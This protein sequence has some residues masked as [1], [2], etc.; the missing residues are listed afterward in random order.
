MRTGTIWVDVGARDISGLASVLE[1][2]TR[3]P[4]ES[5]RSGDNIRGFTSIGVN[6]LA[7]HS[8]FDTDITVELYGKQLPYN[9]P[10][11]PIRQE[12]NESVF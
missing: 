1:F 4:T 6:P 8:D 9:A 12:Y 11:D 2:Q 3:M 5:Y 7:Y 10:I